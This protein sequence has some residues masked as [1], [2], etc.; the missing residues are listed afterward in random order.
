VALS[1]ETLATLRTHRKAQLELK[2]RN[3]A[4][5]ADHG[6]IFARE[7]V[8]RTATARLGDPL[9]TLSESRFQTLVKDAGV[10]QIKFHGTRHT[11][12]TLSLAAGVPP[13]VVADRLGHSTQELLKTYAHSL[14]DMQLDAA[15][16]LGALLHG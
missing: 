16:R 4:T 3:R 2:M 9:T 1:A 11:V 10:K 12:A 13:H 5:Y 7:D 14:P 15:A 8:D 6:L